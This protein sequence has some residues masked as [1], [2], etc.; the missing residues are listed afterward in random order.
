MHTYFQPNEYEQMFIA[1]GTIQQSELDDEFQEYLRETKGDEFQMDYSDW[2]SSRRKLDELNQV[3]S[4]EIEPI[5][6]AGIRPLTSSELLSENELL[7]QMSIL[8]SA[9]GY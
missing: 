3:Y 7:N 8:E 9:L 6:R 2:N 1:A 5:Y 4:K